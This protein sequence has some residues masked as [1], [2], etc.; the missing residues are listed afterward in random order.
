MLPQNPPQP[1]C[2]YFPLKLSSVGIQ[3]SKLMIESLV[4][5]VVPATRQNAGSPVFVVQPGL[6]VMQPGGVLNVPPAT[7]WATVT[8]A[9]GNDRFTKP[10]QLLVAETGVVP[11]TIAASETV[12][13]VTALN[14][15]LMAILPSWHPSWLVL[16]RPGRTL[17]RRQNDRGRKHSFAEP[18]Q[19]QLFMFTPF[20]GVFE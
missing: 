8:T 16:L 14:R 5:V 17:Q 7:D 1:T 9:P 13:T 2:S 10:S 18:V 4:G 15:R 11:S 12:E 20:S 3:T 19:S 6:P